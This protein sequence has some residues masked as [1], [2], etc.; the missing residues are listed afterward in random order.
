MLELVQAAGVVAVPVGG[1]RE[2]RVPEEIGGGAGQRR[3]PETRIDDEVPLAPPDVPDVAPEDP[4]DVR[5]PQD[6]DRVVDAAASEPGGSD[7]KLHALIVGEPP[8]GA[9]YPV[10][11]R[12]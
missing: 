8:A 2:R 9:G 4:V 5:F 1:H 6:G 12:P 7:R 3:D 10:V 11:T